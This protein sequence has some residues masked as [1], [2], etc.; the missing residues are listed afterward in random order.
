MPRSLKRKSKAFF[1]ILG[2][3]ALGVAIVLVLYKILEFLNDAA[4]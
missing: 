2:D 3:L 4:N 1:E